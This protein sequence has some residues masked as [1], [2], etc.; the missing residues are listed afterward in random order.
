MTC[1]DCGASDIETLKYG[2]RFCGRCRIAFL[3]DEAGAVVE[4]LERG[5]APEPPKHAFNPLL[6][7]KPQQFTVRSA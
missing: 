1:P 3:R 4:R 5:Q 6:P 2:W 7:A